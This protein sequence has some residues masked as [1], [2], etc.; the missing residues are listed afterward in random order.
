MALAT[1][2]TPASHVLQHAGLSP[3]LSRGGPFQGDGFVAE[4]ASDLKWRQF[5]VKDCRVLVIGAGGLGCELLKD[6]A[7]SGFTQ[8]DCVDMD[9]ID[10]SNLNRQFLF[11]PDDVGKAKADVAAAFINKRIPG[12]NVVA[13]FGKIQDFDEDFYQN[14][15]IVVAGLDS[16]KARRWLNQM[17]V[18]LAEH[19]YDD[20]DNEL[21]AWDMETI[22]PLVDGGTEGFKGQ[23]RVIFPH[24]TPCFECLLDLFPEDPL[25]FAMC[26]VA[27]TPRQPEHCIAWA[28]MFAWPQEKG[29]EL[30][31][32][33]DDPEHITWLNA[34]ATTRAAEF[35]IEGVN[36][37]LTQGVVKR[38]IPAIASTNA[39]VA[40]SCANEAFKICTGASHYLKNYM[41]YNG[42]EGLY[43]STVNY[44]KNEHCLVCGTVGVPL[45]FP[46]ATTLQELISHFIEDTQ[47]FDT[48]RDPSLVLQLDDGGSTP[49][50]MTGFLS[51][52]TKPNLVKPLSELF[53]SGA[54]ISITDRSDKNINYVVRVNL[55]TP[56]PTVEDALANGSHVH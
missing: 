5:L 47:K 53:A 38:I 31:I 2:H 14:F 8:I 23:S 18:S 35:S 29:E 4:T 24:L 41:M 3:L 56:K 39:V 37:K 32:D 27:V 1:P 6:L 19:E 28:M 10:Y 16:V 40:A 54:T 50:W 12:V 15:H 51:A 21:E 17:L 33:G 25:N 45:S 30:K 48:L 43:T 7:L 49:L 22:I 42:G 52:R 11:R 34:Q 20:D 44:E 46:A 9:T 26:T 13:H 55:T 36:Y